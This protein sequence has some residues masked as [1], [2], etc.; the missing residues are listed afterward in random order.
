[1]QGITLFIF[2][3]ITQKERKKRDIGV[4]VFTLFFCVCCDHTHNALCIEL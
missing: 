1:M 4:I 3:I 2:V